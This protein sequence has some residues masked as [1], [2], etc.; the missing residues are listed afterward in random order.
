MASRQEQAKIISSNIKRLRD[1][2]KWKQAKLAAEAGITAA[3]LSKIEKGEDRVPTIVVIRKLANALNVEPY[4][5]TG[6]AAEEGSEK[7]VAR[8]ELY[9]RFKDILDLD[10]EDQELLLDMTRR[11]KEI[12]KSE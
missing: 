4:E 8:K 3:A 5:I 7:Q 6:E 1:G 11:L 9:R 10:D 2:M 12:K